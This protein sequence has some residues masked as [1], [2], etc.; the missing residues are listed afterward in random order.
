MTTSLTDFGATG[1]LV[2]P[3]QIGAAKPRLAITGATNGALYLVNR[4]DLGGFAPSGPDRVVKTL[5]LPGGIYGT[6]AYWQSTVYVAAAGDALKAYPLTGG[7]LADVPSSQSG[8]IIGGAGASPT[9]SSNG[10]S[11]GV[12]WVVD[13]SG[14]DSGAPAVLRAF[15]ATNLGVE[16]YNSSRKPED[17]AGA[18]ARLA[19]PTVANGRVYV[20]TQNEVTVYGLVP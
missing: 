7:I 18:A 11:S 17:A 6:P 3:D 4:D 12:V 2:V 5:N 13:T 16:L 8:P 10:G 9:I 15:D 19:V 14:A 1:V 20:G